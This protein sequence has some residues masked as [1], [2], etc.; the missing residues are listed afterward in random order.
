ME[1]VSSQI[2]HCLQKY[3]ILWF[4]FHCNMVTI[5]LNLYIFFIFSTFWILWRKMSTD[6]LK[7][8]YAD[9]KLSF[10]LCSLI[11]LM[12]AFNTFESTYL[13]H[14][15]NVYVKFGKIILYVR[16]TFI[17]LKIAW[18]Q[19]KVLLIVLHI[20]NDRSWMQQ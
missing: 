12:T 5:M 2:V 15:M 18:Y 8:K 20:H 7:C 10:L 17:A 14:Q 13:T 11:E 19:Q 4:F 16:K 1:Y 3:Q 9:G 6:S